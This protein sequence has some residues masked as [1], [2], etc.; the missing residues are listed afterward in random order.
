M[1]ERTVYFWAQDEK[2][3][4]SCSMNEGYP[5]IE[6]A[7]EGI[8]EESLGSDGWKLHKVQFVSTR[9][10]EVSRE[11]LYRTAKMSAQGFYSIEEI[12]RMALAGETVPTPYGPM[13]FNKNS[14]RWERADYD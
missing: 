6:A 9:I 4:M 11:E 10:E 1:M 5:S 2:Y 12:N 14:S 7:M 8:S 3:L 13:R